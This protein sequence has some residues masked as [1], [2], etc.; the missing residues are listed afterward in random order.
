MKT[1]TCCITAQLFLTLYLQAQP[2][3]DRNKLISFYQ[4]QEYGRA[5]EYLLPFASGTTNAVQYYNDLG[6]SYFMN[7]QPDEALQS[8]MTV[9]QLQ[10]SN[11]LANLY[12]AQIWAGRKEHDSTLFYYKNLIY[13]QPSNYRFW[14]RAGQVFNTKANYDSAK[15]YYQQ[16]YK[17]NPRSGSLVVQYC[18]VLLRLRDLKKAD[19]I[20]RRFLALDSSNQEVISKRIDLSFRQSQYSTVINW[21]ERLWKDSADVA[22]PYINLAYS[23]LAVDSLDKC[24]RLC[25]WLMMKNKATVVLVYCASQAYAKKKNYTRS[26]ELLD[27]CLTLSMQTDA[28]RYFN[29]KSDNYE[30]MKQY[31]QALTYYDT[32]YYIFQ[33]P[34]DLYYT[35]RLYDKYLNNKT[36]ARFYY[37]QYIDKAKAPKN[38]G[39][40]IVFDYIKEYLNRKD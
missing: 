29:A 6:Y 39:E 3:Y 19:T 2:A 40:K 1:I 16:G 32:S 4:D 7:E 15:W 33:T 35:G 8:F 12:A 38:S 34:S 22:S 21:G 9:Y 36:K 20:L 14:Q 23:Y 17:L 31:N 27:D 37:Q 30:A 26:N 5:I 25:E 18:D 11:T 28:V 13:Y 10:P 24:I